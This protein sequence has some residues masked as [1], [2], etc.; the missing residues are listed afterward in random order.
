MRLI[1]IFDPAIQ[2][3]YD[4]FQRGI[5]QVET[6][7]VKDSILQNAR[8]VE[9]ERMDQVMHS[10]QDQYPLAK[11]TKIMLGVVWPDHHVAFPDFL[12]PTNATH[13]WWISEFVNFQKQLSFD[14]I[15][16]DM[17]EPSN[18][19]TNDN[20]P[21]YYGSADHP[22]ALP[23]FCPMKDGDKDSQYDM[24]PYKTHNVWNYGD[25]VSDLGSAINTD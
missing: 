23:L 5:N 17:N 11:N 25:N 1:P 14:G 13:N 24:P 2:A 4:V 18:F 15:W 3:D 16:I 6:C 21:W 20:N 7:D 8:F 19:G 10:I 9:W 22:N 12:D